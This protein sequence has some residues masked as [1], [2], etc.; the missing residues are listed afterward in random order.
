MFLYSTVIILIFV[1]LCWRIKYDDDDDAK[2]SS[3]NNEIC[4]TSGVCVHGGADNDYPV[5]PN[6]CVFDYKFVSEVYLV[7]Q[8]MTSHVTCM[9]A[10]Y[11]QFL[12]VNIIRSIV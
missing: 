11:N 4:P 6:L 5:D 10:I 7:V 8:D 9:C 1:M 2:Y 3:F 12:R